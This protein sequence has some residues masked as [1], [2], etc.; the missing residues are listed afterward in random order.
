MT[1]FALGTAIVLFTVAAPVQFGEQA[2]AAVIWAAEAAALTW[3]A[4]RTGMVFFRWAGYA[5]FFITA[6]RLLIVDTG[7][8]L[9]TFTP[10]LNHRFL[11]FAVGIA[12]MYLAG[13]FIAK[14]RGRLLGTEARAAVPVFFIA[15][16]FFTLWLFTAEI[17]NTFD[18]ALLN[19]GEYYRVYG[20]GTV[21]RNLQNLS[22]TA[23]WAVY[24]I[25]ALVVGILRRVR[26]LRL[27]ALVLLLIAIGKV[28]VYDV[29]NLAMVY[30]IIA[31]TGLGLLLIA[32]GYLYQRYR[33]RIVTFLKE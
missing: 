18:K 12:A 1:L 32:A 7:V 27:A 28:F 25:G 2:W 24:A 8:T 3:L 21:L 5:V 13:Y 17:L 19:R 10:V 16:S 31:F 30:R 33:T 6:F 4:I 29:F 11:A 14:G 15:A 22:I 20:Q 23:L 9:A 26:F